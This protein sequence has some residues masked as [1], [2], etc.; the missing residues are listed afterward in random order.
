MWTV[1]VVNFGRTGTA[2]GRIVVG[3][4]SS[5]MAVAALSPTLR[6][7]R[8]AVVAEPAA[9]TTGPERSILADGGVQVRYPDG[10]IVI[11]GPGCGSTTINPDGTVFRAMCNQVQ[12]ATLPAVPSDP[13]LR[14][15]LESHRDHLLE[16]IA[17]LV[18]H[19]QSEVDLYLA[20]EA[21]NAGGLF[22]QLQMRTRLIDSLLR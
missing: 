6:R 18:D 11:Y 17:Q 22:E 5:E 12:P 2:I 16:Q 20:Y 19:R 15:F 8:D 7:L 14:T 21:S 4:P 10:R 13:A 3:Y 9:P 1:S